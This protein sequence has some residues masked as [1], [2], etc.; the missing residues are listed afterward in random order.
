MRAFLT[1]IAGAIAITSAHAEV[2]SASEHGFVLEH[3]VTS[4]FA[5]DAL[6][7]RLMQPAQWWDPDHTYSGDAANLSMEDT[8]GAYW[9][10]DWDTGSVIHG[11]VLLVKEGEELILSAPFG[12]LISTAA[13]C[14]WT[15][16]L[17][18][19]EDGGTL[20]K[21]SHTIAG[22][23]GTGLEELAPAVDF[24]MGNGVKRLAGVE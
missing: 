6:W 17:E 18:P 13:D 15:I 2:A 10:E 20:I 7:H 24:V 8:A 22:V 16:R 5:P 14:R 21:S 19:T 9:R 11:Q 12:P 4:P 1:A 23:P 3:E